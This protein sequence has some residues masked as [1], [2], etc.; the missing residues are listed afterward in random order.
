MFFR[1]V[2]PIL[3][4]SN[5]K[6]VKT[7]KFGDPKYVGDPLNALRIF[8]DK[9]VDELAVLDISPDRKDRGPDLEFI[10]GLTSECFM[11]LLYGGGVSSFEQMREI[12]RVGVE[13]IALNSAIISNPDLVLQATSHFGSQSI[14]AAIDFR[15]N[16]KNAQ[17][18]ND[19]E[20]WFV[21]GTIGM[22]MGV[23]ELARQLEAMGVGE[24]L[25]QSIDRDGT[26]SGY[27]IDAI[28]SVCSA[29][30]IPVIACGGAASVDDLALAIQ[31][32][33]ASAAG[34]G[35]LFVFCGGR[36]SILLTYPSR[37]DLDQITGA[38]Q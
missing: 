23:V 16:Q 11:P 35:S 10:R 34:A 8:N 18:K 19:L 9:R 38:L 6:L 13:K 20:P 17:T 36:N 14:V 31:Q 26:F 33:G 22:N 32:G 37:A 7:V 24:L 3:L 4:V 2:I 30:H 25:L 5:R 27:D 28:Q 1:R 21:S 29:V 15:R 12:F